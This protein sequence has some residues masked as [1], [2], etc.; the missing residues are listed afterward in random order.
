MMRA[1]WAE[2]VGGG[3]RSNLH[4]MDAGLSVM[5]ARG[6]HLGAPDRRTVLS[7]I[8]RYGVNSS[9]I[10]KGIET[11]KDWHSFYFVEKYRRDNVLKGPPRRPPLRRTPPQRRFCARL[12]RPRAC[13]AS[14]G[15]ACLCVCVSV[16][17]CVC[18]CVSVRLCVCLRV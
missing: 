13:P 1:L 3:M 17:R 12:L 15:S 18:V 16:C 11:L 2:G 5:R 14:R 8:Y 4:D 9:Q 6:V 7:Q 10:P